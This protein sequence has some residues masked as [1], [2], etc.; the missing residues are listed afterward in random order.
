VRIPPAAFTPISF[1]PF[2]AI[3]P[4]FCSMWHLPADPVRSLDEVGPGVHCQPACA[5]LS[6]SVKS[7]GLNDHL[8]RASPRCAASQTARISASTARSSPDLSRPMLIT[9]SISR[10]PAF[11]ACSVSNVFTGVVAA[12]SGKHD[13]HTATPESAMPPRTGDV[14]GIYTQTEAK[15]KR[16]ALLADGFHIGQAWLPV[17]T[18]VWSIIAASARS[19]GSI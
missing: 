1:R 15:R 16:S 9:I 6:S 7:A 11:S 2:A 3:N 8:H 18:G 4:T 10:A 19:N 17:S 5:D 13:V 14:T 12:P